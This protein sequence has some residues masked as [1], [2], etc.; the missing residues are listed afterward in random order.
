MTRLGIAPGPKRLELLR[1]LIP[2]AR[3]VALLVNP[4]NPAA[5]HQDISGVQEAAGRLEMEIVVVDAAADTEFE[6]P[7][8]PR[9]SR[10]P[11]LSWLAPMHF[12]LVGASR[13]L[14]WLC[15]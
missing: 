2:T 12:S 8:R 11:P 6:S 1:E 3:K 4:S 15:A 7:S 5:S 10:V 13:L 9:S 14:R